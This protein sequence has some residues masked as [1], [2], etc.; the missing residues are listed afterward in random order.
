MI[1]NFKA[2]PDSSNK[3]TMQALWDAFYSFSYMTLFTSKRVRFPKIH[4][5][6]LFTFQ[7]N[8]LCFSSFLLISPAGF[9]AIITV[10]L[11]YRFPLWNQITLIWSRSFKY[12]FWKKI[13]NF[14]FIRQ[15][16]EAAFYSFCSAS[17]D[18]TS[19]HHYYRI[20]KLKYIANSRCFKVL[21]LNFRIK[22]RVRSLGR[23]LYQEP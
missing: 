16:V 2:A 21:K 7:I 23:S 12:F 9:I 19:L 8:D 14:E 20:T 15:K 4:L 22:T 11:I 3:N 1:W 13:V 17:E 18:A 10:S 6:V 5:N